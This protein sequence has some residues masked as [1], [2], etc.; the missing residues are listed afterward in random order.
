MLSF[1]DIEDLLAER[2]VMVSYESIR[3]W[4]H[5]VGPAYAR[6]LRKRA[7]CLGDTWFMD[8][9]MITTVLGERCYL[10]RAVDQ[11]NQVI[12]I[13]VQK[14]KDTRAAARF[15]KKMLKHPGRTPRRMVT[16]KLRSYGAARNKIMPSVVHDQDRYANNR[17]EAFH[18]PTR[19]QER[20]MRGFKSAGQAQ[21][22]LAMHGQVHNPFRVGRHLMRAHHY[23]LFRARSY[24]IWRQTTC[25]C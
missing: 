9:V 6:R 13:L 21:R 12:D 10:W 25:V 4:C 19:Q 14:H 20:Q 15:F 5:K 11:D 1:R 22:F 23:R 7:G 24:S 3:L 8:E 2:G 18:Q 17:A 16:D